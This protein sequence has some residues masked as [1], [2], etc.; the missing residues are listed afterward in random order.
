MLTPRSLLQIAKPPYFFQPFQ[1]LKRLRL[2]FYWRSRRDA[3]VVL[4]WGLP[5]KID[6]HEAI[7][8]SIASQGLYEIGLTESLWRLTEPGDLAIDA[9]ANIGYTAS[10]LGIRVGAGGRVICFEPHPLVFDSLK[11]NVG[12]WKK[13]RRSG[14]FELHQEALGAENGEALLHTSDWFRTNR[15]T[16]WISDATEA[17]PDFRTIEVPIRN[18]DSIFGEVAAIGVLKM[19]LQGHELGVLHGTVRL[20]DR[21]A[22]R[23][24][25]FEE[26]TAVPSPVHN[27]LKSHVYL[28]FGI[29][30]AFTGVRCLA[31]AQPVFDPVTGPVPNYLATIEPERAMARLSQG[32]WQSFG[33]ARLLASHL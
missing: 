24:I 10:I 15:G 5:I 22:I 16:A 29:Q 9:G 6:P 27:F 14:S 7:G 31:H 11:A 3:S 28:I 1:A 32:M 26:E 30:E 20:L 19:D 18:L 33:P 25:I 17:S 2:E 13:D 8:Y 4:P 21:H 12:V 23:D